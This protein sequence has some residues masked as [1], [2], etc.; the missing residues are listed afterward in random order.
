MLN[1][2]HYAHLSDSK[3]KLQRGYDLHVCM[4]W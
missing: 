1:Q 3:A 4:I 2:N